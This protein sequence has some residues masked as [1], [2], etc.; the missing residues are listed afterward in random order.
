MVLS[1]FL[2]KKNERTCN[3]KLKI[4]IF[5]ILN[6][7]DEFMI[8]AS[9]ERNLLYDWGKHPKRENCNFSSKKLPKWNFTKM[10][11][12]GRKSLQKI[13]SLRFR[14]LWNCT[15]Q[16]KKTYCQYYV[17]LWRYS[18]FCGCEFTNSHL[19]RRRGRTTPKGSGF[20]PFL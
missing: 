12:Y 20:W 6:F 1:D 19:V 8:S 16:Q 10:Q 15:F 9:S 7:Y 13:M 14:I 2:S 11:F 18:H 5:Q 3:R 4:C 17:R